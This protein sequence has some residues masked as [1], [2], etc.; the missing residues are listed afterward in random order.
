MRIKEII[1][2]TKGQLLSGNPE[3]EV[4]GFT[5]DTRLLVPG[6]GFVALKGD[7]T[8]GHA[9]LKQALDRGAKVLIVEHEV[10]PMDTNVVLVEDGLKALADMA[11]YV[12]ARF[13]GKVVGITGSVGKTTTKDMIYSVV[14]TKFKTLKTLGNY[15]NFIGLPLTILRYQDEE[16]MVI[17]MG[18]N[19]LGEIDYLTRI[20]R[21]H[22]GVITNVGT[23]HIGE[24]GSR[25]KI[26]AAKMEITHGLEDDGKLIINVDND[27]LSTVKSDGSYCLETIGIK[28]DADLKA[29]DVILNEDMSSFK[30]KVDGQIHHVYVYHPGMHYVYNALVAIKIGLDLGISIEDCIEGVAHAEITKSRND[31]IVVGENIRIIDGTYN[32]NL[33]SMRAGIDVL[34]GYKGR[35]IAVVGDMKEL[36]TYSERIHR[37]VGQYLIKNEIDIV[38]GVGRL[39]YYICNEVN[40]ARRHAVHFRSNDELKVYLNDI[41][42]EGDIILV[43]GSHSMNLK[44][45][46]DYMKE[47]N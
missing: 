38:L 19:H 33:D 31:M 14:A 35:K 21:P 17:E 5:Q 10:E 45:V 22:I 1:E 41:V 2:A 39:A 37:L 34:A 16:V 32:A 4:Q 9:Y 18:M 30:I 47:M 7:H 28:A 26:L 12:R 46:V 13:K 29:Y 20:A 44:Q 27:L 43:K 42:E 8:D 23:A 15:N 24:V 11:K 40:K 36:G 6:N 3:D 25:E